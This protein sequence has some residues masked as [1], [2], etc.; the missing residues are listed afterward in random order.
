METRGT[1]YFFSLGIT[2]IFLTTCSDI[3]QS[4]SS[5]EV[6]EDSTATMPAVTQEEDLSTLDT[7]IGIFIDADAEDNQDKTSR[8]TA[9]YL[10]SATHN[11]FTHPIDTFQN[12]PYGFEEDELVTYPDSIYQKRFANITSAMPLVY[13]PQ[14][15]NFIDLYAIRKKD[16]T[17]RMFGKSMLY[18]PYI[19]KVLMEKDLPHD[20][21]YLTMVESALHADARSHMEAVGLWQIRYRT[22]KWL[23]LE[24]NDY[25]D[26]RRDPYQSTKAAASY[27]E[28]LHGIYGSWPMALAAYNSGP[29]NVNRAI[30][31]AGGSRD[32][33]RVNKYLP[34]ETRSYVP[35]F[36][37]I[38]YLNRYQQEH[39]IRPVLPDLPFQAVDTARIYHEASFKEIARELKMD[40]ENLVF[41]NPALIKQKVP[42][43]REGWPIV[44]PMRKT[45][46]LEEK[47]ADLLTQDLRYEV[48]KTA[49]VLKER[50]EIVP[51]NTDLNL[52][53]HRIRRGQT[54]NGIAKKYGVSLDQIRAWNAMRN[55]TIR[56]GQTLKI[57][58][59]DSQFARY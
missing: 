48:A 4:V 54:M 5:L 59:P 26:E 44:L 18:F 52:L 34:A 22:G 21:K 35:A 38:V 20:L 14:V 8:F 40:E 43:L 24:I 19:E 45:A 41:L 50:K 23:G 42:A 27:L 1:Y 53:E 25:L 47:R 46:L 16:L 31:R 56:T 9:T 55:N 49:Q 30:V 2:F 36:M 11:L 29:G 51:E 17:E 32:F 28:R 37:A 15:K 39:N 7:I 57:Y 58:V 13:N 3:E 12:N 6:G 33:W 10:D